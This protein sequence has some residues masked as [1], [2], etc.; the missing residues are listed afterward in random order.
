MHNQ[1]AMATGLSSIYAEPSDILEHS[2]CNSA[3]SD[4]NSYENVWEQG[5]HLDHDSS[6]VH[7]DNNV[8]VLN[9]I[10]QKPS[11]FLKDNDDNNLRTSDSNSYASIFEG[12]DYRPLN[13]PYKDDHIRGKKNCLENISSPDS[14]QYPGEKGYA[15]SRNECRSQMSKELSEAIEKLENIGF[16]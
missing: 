1:G 5:P 12:D 6:A 16:N 4:S 11:D 8:P 10:Y 15:S 7:C 2:Q 13:L 14:R 3:L 9:S